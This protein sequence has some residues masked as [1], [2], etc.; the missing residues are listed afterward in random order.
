MKTRTDP[1]PIVYVPMSADII[2]PG[3]IDVLSYAATKGTVVVGLLT[4]Q[5]I[6]DKKGHLPILSYDERY[7]VVAHLKDVSKIIPKET[8]DYE[9]ELRNLRPAFMVHGDDWD[10]A[11]ITQVEAILHEWGG[12]LL[13]VD[14]SSY[15]ASSSA[16][17]QRVIDQRS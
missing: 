3:H 14:Y 11:T 9:P 13:L 6:L 12:K 1:Q 15:P 4:D 8:T 16:I 17:K 2:H 5:A 7:K 10:K